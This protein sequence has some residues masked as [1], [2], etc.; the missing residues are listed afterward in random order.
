MIKK[1][2]IMNEIEYYETYL[3]NV[4][5]QLERIKR[6]IPNGTSLIA[7]RHGN[8]YQYYS[9]VKG[10]KGRSGTY[11]RKDNLEMAR[12]LAQLEYD[13]KLKNQLQL[14]INGLKEVR[15]NIDKNPFEDVADRMTQGKR[16]LV[17]IPYTSDESYINEWLKQ[18][19]EKLGFREGSP[20]YSTR[21]NLKVRSKSEVIIADMLDEVGIPF[22]YEKP[23]KLYSIVVHPDFTLLNLRERKEVYWEHFGMMDDAEYK[24]N[25]LLKIGEYEAMYF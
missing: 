20:R 8:R 22:L 5:E 23:L 18:E 10:S 12:K 13:L 17:D 19:Y 14:L 1:E 2:D 11:I 4:S 16:V 24:N 21:N 6:Q 15:S 7:A 9:R 3:T 25:T